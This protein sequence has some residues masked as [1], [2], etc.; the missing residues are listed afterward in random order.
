MENKDIRLCTKCNNVL[1]PGET[2]CPHCGEYDKE[3]VVI[4]DAAT[5]AH[6][7]IRLCTK[8]NNVLVPGETVCPH[9]G[10]YDKG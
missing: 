8:C 2:V 5:M 4:E 10:E 7:D 1:V 6:E 3:P 9:C